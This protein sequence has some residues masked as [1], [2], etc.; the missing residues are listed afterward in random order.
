MNISATSAFHTKIEAKALGNGTNNGGPTPEAKQ[1]RGDR[2]RYKNEF[3]S[4]MCDINF[5]KTIP[6][7]SVHQTLV[8][9]IYQS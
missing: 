3:C 2:A 5:L 9:M 8:A 6:F 4:Y 7:N 1:S